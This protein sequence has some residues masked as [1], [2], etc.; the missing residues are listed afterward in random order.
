MPEPKKKSRNQKSIPGHTYE[1]AVSPVDYSNITD[2]KVIHKKPQAGESGD[3]NI[4]HKT[5][6][7]QPDL[8]KKLIEFI[9]TL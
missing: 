6:S 5:D 2:V 8:V 7:L 4:I 1:V 9:E 3:R